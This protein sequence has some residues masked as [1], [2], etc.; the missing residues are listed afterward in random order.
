MR[1]VKRDVARVKTDADTRKPRNAAA[2]QERLKQMPKR[3]LEGAVTSAANRTDGHGLG[4][5]SLQAPRAAK[6]DP[7]VQESTGRM[8][9]RTLLR[10]AT[11]VRI[12]E[13]APKSKTKRWEVLAG[14]SRKTL[15]FTSKPWGS[16]EV[17]PP[18]VGR[19][20][21]DPDANQSGCR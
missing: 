6:D 2:E 18:Q 4:R 21:Y 12:I 1:S 5:A 15:Q 19:H 8:T 20:R 16:G 3:I 17:C 14:V 9:N 11:A 7:E 10:S 13:C